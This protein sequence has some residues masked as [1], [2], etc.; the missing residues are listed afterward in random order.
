MR[1]A[2]CDNDELIRIQINEYLQDIFH[3]SHLACPEIAMFENGESLLSDSGE[4]DVVF[5]DIEMPGLNGIHVGRELRKAN[6]HT[7]IFIVSA[8]PEYLDDAM[9]FHVFRYLSKPIDRHRLIQNMK[10]ALQLYITTSSKIPLET[11]DEVY[12][13]STADIIAIE[14]QTR[15]VIVYT[16]DSKYESIHNMAYWTD[17]LNEKCF[18]QTHRS[19]IVNMMHVNRF[20]RNLVY[21]HNGQIVAY[22]TKRKYTEFKNTYL[23]YME[24]VR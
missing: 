4:K 17:L 10:D 21:L 1:I 3:N 11:K 2:I 24:I 23:L 7:I 20:D 19:F 13:I 6:K 15:K 22:L 12:T 16:T 14:A 5:L 9:R 18:F 8:F